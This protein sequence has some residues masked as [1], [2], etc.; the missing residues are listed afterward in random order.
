[1]GVDSKALTIQVKYFGEKKKYNTGKS[2]AVIQ[3]I[4]KKTYK[5]SNIQ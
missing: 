1:M 5:V 3:I 4:L 2:Y